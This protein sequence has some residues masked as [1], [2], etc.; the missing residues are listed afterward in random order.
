MDQHMECP[1]TFFG[2]TVIPV[3]D[4]PVQRCPQRPDEGCCHLQLGVTW[5]RQCRQKRARPV[6]GAG[7]CTKGVGMLF[8]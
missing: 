7:E 1:W 5:V 8:R 2:E 3:K 4:H 6:G